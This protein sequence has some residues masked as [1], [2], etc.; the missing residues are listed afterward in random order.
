[1]RDLE[2][3]F[4][5]IVI[6]VTSFFLIFNKLT[7]RADAKVDTLSVNSIVQQTQDI[8]I[9][10][11][12]KSAGYPDDIIAILDEDTKKQYYDEKAL[13]QT[14]E[15]THGIMT[16]DLS[17]E[18]TFNEKGEAILDDS[19]E[20][21]IDKLLDDKDEIKEL[22]NKRN[23][24]MNEN[25]SSEKIINY[26]EGTN[27]TERSIGLRSLSNFTHT[28]VV[29]HLGQDKKTGYS[30]KQFY[31]KWTWK[32]SPAFTYVDTYG[33]AYMG[34]YAIDEN[35][36]YCTQTTKGKGYDKNGIAHYKA[37]TTAQTE[38]SQVNLGAGIAIQYDILGSF[39]YNSIKY[40]PYEYSGTLKVNVEK[41]EM[42]STN[43]IYNV[44]GQ[45]FH[46]QLAISGMSV[47][48]SGDKNA[49]ISISGTTGHDSSPVRIAKF[50]MFK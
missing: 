24:S 48:F 18:I 44:V 42:T 17:I 20:K 33:I 41:K 35:S 47:S 7:I 6:I 38:T 29:T 10:E 11:Y 19:E 4:K 3:N 21:K 22:V 5:R 26:L 30:K 43:P 25:L 2:K 32:Y 15:T 40:I 28:I 14:S 36:F 16:D 12:L 13:Y 49:S 8:S 23:R 1:M 27:K 34:N 46:K 50:N 9:D 39:A 45:Y 37:M 31:Y